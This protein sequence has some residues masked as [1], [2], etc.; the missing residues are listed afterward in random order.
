MYRVNQPKVV[1]ETIDGEVVAIDMASGFYYNLRDWSA[2]A[3]DLLVSG[4]SLNQARSDFASAAPDAPADAFDGFAQAVLDEGL[5]VPVD[6]GTDELAPIAPPTVA[7]QPLEL[8]RF[9]DMSDL[10]LLDPVH[11]VDAETGWPN[12]VPPQ[13]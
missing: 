1:A 3:W 10:I 5:L 12:V 11:E 13:G 8:E 6:E 2:F 4:R 9:T 7:W